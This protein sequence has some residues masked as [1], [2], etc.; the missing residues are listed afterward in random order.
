MVGFILGIFVGT[1]AGIFIAAFLV[2][3]SERLYE[4][5]DGV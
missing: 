5:R 4:K 1:A 2:A 3:D